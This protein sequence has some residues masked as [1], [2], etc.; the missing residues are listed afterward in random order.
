MRR[1]V[2]IAVLLG[3]LICATP[4]RAA[5]VGPDGAQALRNQ[6][7]DWIRAFIPPGTTPPELAIT[8]T[9]EDGH[10]RLSVPLPG[11]RAGADEA[12]LSATAATLPDNRWTVQD[13]VVPPKT[14]FRFGSGKTMVEASL[15]LGDE[16]GSALIDPTF[17][18][19][20]TF[21][22]QAN[23]V[24]FSA[25]GSEQH[26]QQHIDRYRAS[27]SLSAG[28]AGTLVLAEQTTAEGWRAAAQKAAGPAVAFGADRAKEELSISGLDRD[29]V[30]PAIAAVTALVAAWPPMAPSGRPPTVDQLPPVTRAALRTLVEG[31]HGLA[32]TARA[33]ETV[34]NLKVEI[35]GL[36]AASARSMRIGIGGE[37]P[38]GLL[39]VW[40][41]VGVDGLAL[42]G[43]SSE[44]AALAPHQITFRPS[45]AGVPTE[46]LARLAVAAT[47]PGTDPHRLDPE[48][49]ALFAQGSV[50]VGLEAL[51]FTIGPAAFQGAGS[52]LMI[53]QTEMEG[54]ARLTATG[55]DALIDAAHGNP[56][57][58]QALPVLILARAL[59][60]NDGDRLVWDLA[61]TR[62]GSVTLNGVDVSALMGAANR[63]RNQPR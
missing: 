21:D 30:A 3:P 63:G 37:A 25:Q 19:T 6:L 32:A 2:P 9:P 22:V 10:Y 53:S 57:L 59:A 42:H 38:S 58:Q 4:A 1:F 15:G 44:V 52:L 8:V 12:V 49:A 51:A 33:Q 16:H 20:S 50:T 34:E 62:T 7:Q 35:A 26:Q 47:R 36:G 14:T 54:Q 28:P 5:D 55:F 17:A 39:R 43:I 46:A 24:D 60:R 27:G 23:N 61:S 41:D 13:L 18:S 11:M 56:D 40:F 29:R 48:I 31:L 45:I